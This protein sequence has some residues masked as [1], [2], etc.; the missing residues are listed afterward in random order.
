MLVEDLK[1]L[2]R[3]REYY[4]KLMNGE[5]PREGRSEQ[6]AEVED[7][8]TAITSAEIEMALNY[9]T[10]QLTGRSVELFGKN[11]SAFSEGSIEQDHC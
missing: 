4:Q 3:W 6:Q 2:E 7:D 5:N 8:I 10:R 9:W 1:I 11:W